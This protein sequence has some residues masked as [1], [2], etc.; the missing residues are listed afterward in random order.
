MRWKKDYGGNVEAKFITP[1]AGCG[2]YAQGLVVGSGSLLPGAY[3]LSVPP[4]RASSLPDRAS[5]CC[6]GLRALGKLSPLGLATS[7][8]PIALHSSVTQISHVWRAGWGRKRGRFVGVPGGVMMEGGV[9]VG[10][11]GGGMAGVEGV[12]RGVKGGVERG[13][14]GCDG[15]GLGLVRLALGARREE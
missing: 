9:G 3:A 5:G 2:D 8:V 12:E 6:A 10:V 15:G 14:G 11:F 7:V 4:R 13:V 1:D